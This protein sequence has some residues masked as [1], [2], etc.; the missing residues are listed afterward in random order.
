MVK[1]DLGGEGTNRVI[2]KKVKVHSVKKD[3]IGCEFFQ[4]D[5]KDAR[6]G[7]YLL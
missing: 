3:L 2:E 5:K 7:F 6:I 4:Q 1:F